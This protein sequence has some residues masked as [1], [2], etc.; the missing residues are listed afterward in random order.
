MIALAPLRARE[1]AG[2]AVACGRRPDRLMAT[3]NHT[4]ERGR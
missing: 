2:N 3:S 1:H 4:A